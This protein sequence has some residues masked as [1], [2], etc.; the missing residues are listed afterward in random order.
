M[1]ITALNSVI[2]VCV[3]PFSPYI[4]SP[5]C[6]L[7]I[8]ADGVAKHELGNAPLLLS[9]PVLEMHRIRPVETL[10]GTAF[11]VPDDVVT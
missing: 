3:T 11:D 9:F 8:A 6:A 10:K 7:L 4:T 2:D 5:A 1:L